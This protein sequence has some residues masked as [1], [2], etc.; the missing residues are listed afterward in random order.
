[1]ERGKRR[2]LVAVF[3]AAAVAACAAAA[4]APDA[5]AGDDPA[6]RGALLSLAAALLGGPGTL[7][8]AAPGQAAWGDAAGSY[9]A[10]RGV[11]CCSAAAALLPQPCGAPRAVVA[12]NLSGAGLTGALPQSLEPALAS[13]LQLLLLSHNPRLAGGWPAGLVLPQ[14][15][16]VDVR[17]TSL[18]GCLEDG[19]VDLATLLAARRAAAAVLVSAPCTLPPAMLPLATQGVLGHPPFESQLVCPR[20]ALAS[21]GAIDADAAFTHY[22]GC[23][24]ER[25]LDALELHTATDGRARLA[26]ADG[27][28]AARAA[29]R[30]SLLLVGVLPSAFLLL[31]ALVLRWRQLVNAAHRVWRVRRAAASADLAVKLSRFPGTPSIAL[32]RGEGVLSVSDVMVT[33]AVTDVEG[34]TQLWEWDAAVMDDAVERHNQVLRALLEEHGGHEVRTDGDSLT[35]AFH[36]AVDAVRWAV[37][38]QEALLAHP[39]PQRLL[40]HPHAAVVHLGDACLAGVGGPGGGAIS[41]TARCALTGQGPRIMAGLRVRIGINTGVPADVFVHDVTEAVE[42]RGDEYD[43]AADICDIAAGGQILLGP[44]TYQRW[45]RVFS[46]QQAPPDAAALRQSVSAARESMDASHHGPRHHS[47]AGWPRASAAGWPLPSLPDDE[48]VAHAA[49]PPPAGRRLTSSEVGGY[50]GDPPHGAAGQ[51]RKSFS[52]IWS[53]L[54]LAGGGGGGGGHGAHDAGTPLRFQAGR[55]S[56]G[57][58]SRLSSFWTGAGSGSMGRAS[59]TLSMVAQTAPG[60]A[61]LLPPAQPPPS[62]HAAEAARPAS[63]GAGRGGSGAISFMVHGPSGAAAIRPPPAARSLPSR[64]S[65]AAAAD[66]AL[67]AVGGGDGSDA[68]PQPQPQPQPPAVGGRFR[69]TMATRSLSFVPG[70]GAVEAFAAGSAPAGAAAPPAAAAPAAVERSSRSY[71][72]PSPRVRPAARAAGRPLGEGVEPAPPQGLADPW[73]QWAVHA[74]ATSSS[75]MACAK[76]EPVLFPRVPALSAEYEAWRGALDEVVSP[77]STGSADSPSG[78]SLDAMY[79]GL[80]AGRA[81]RTGRSSHLE[82]AE[83]MPPPPRQAADGHLHPMGPDHE[84]TWASEAAAVLRSAGAFV[85]KSLALGRASISGPGDD[86]AATLAGSDAASVRAPCSALIVDMGTYRWRDDD[87]GSS[88]DGDGGGVSGSGGSSGP[89]AKLPLHGQGQGYGRHVT[90]GGMQDDGAEGAAAPG[91]QPQLR[92]PPAPALHLVQVLPPRLSSR[93]MLLPWPLPACIGEDPLLAQ[94]G[95]G[96]LDAPGAFASCPSHMRSLWEA[97]GQP[98]PPR[99]DVTMVF[100]SA[101]GLKEMAA[102]NA[103][104]SRTCHALF[105]RAARELLLLSGGYES[106]EVGGSLMAAF[107]RPSDALE[108]ALALQLALLKVPWPAE[109][110]L[111]GATATVHGPPPAV[112][113]GAGAAAAATEAAGGAAESPNSPPGSGLPSPEETSTARRAA[114]L[115]FAGVRARV[116][117][118]RGPMDRVLPHRV[119]GRADYLGPPANRAA[120]LMAAA[121]GGQIMLEAGVAAAVAREWASRAAQAPSEPLAPPAAAA[122][123]SKAPAQ[124]EPQAPQHSSFEAWRRMADDSGNRAGSAGASAQLP[125]IADAAGT[126]VDGRQLHAPGRA[127]PHATPPATQ[128]GDPALRAA[129]HSG[130]GSGSGASSGTSSAWNFQRPAG[131]RRGSMDLHAPHLLRSQLQ[132]QHQQHQ[133]SAHGARDV[134]PLAHAGSATGSAAWQFLEGPGG[135]GRRASTGGPRSSVELGG[136]GGGMAVEVAPASYAPHAVASYQHSHSS[137]SREGPARRH[138]IALERA[139]AGAAAGS[140]SARDA[141]ARAAAAGST[142]GS[143]SQASSHRLRYAPSADEAEAGTAAAPDTAA[144]PTRRGGAG[145]AAPRRPRASLE[146]PQA[147]G[148]AGMPGVRH[149]RPSIDLGATAA[150]GSVT[151][152][153]ASIDASAAQATQTRQHQ[154]ALSGTV[155]AEIADAVRAEASGPGAARSAPLPQLPASFGSGAGAPA[156]QAAG[157]LARRPAPLIILAGSS[158]EDAEE[159]ASADGCAPAL[160]AAAGPAAAPSQPG[161]GCSRGATPRATRDSCEAQG[162]PPSPSQLS[163]LESLRARRH[164]RALALARGEGS[165]SASRASLQLAA[166]RGAATPPGERQPGGQQR[167]DGGAGGSPACASE[168]PLLQAVA[169]AP[170]GEWGAPA[171]GGEGDSRLRSGSGGASSGMRKGTESDGGS[172]DNRSGSGGRRSASGSGGR[173]PRR[174]RFQRSGAGGG[175]ASAPRRPSFDL[176][177]LLRWGH[178]HGFSA[179]GGPPPPD[180]PPAGSSSSRGASRSGAATAAGAGASAAGAPPPPSQRGRSGSGSGA[181]AAASDGAAAAAIIS[182]PAVAAQCFRITPVGG[183]VGGGAAAPL[184]G[185]GVTYIRYSSLPSVQEQ[186]GDESVGKLTAVA[187]GEAPRGHC[188]PRRVPVRVSL[189]HCGEF[190]LKGVQELVAVVQALPEALEGRLAL[191]APAAGL[192]GK[193]RCVNASCGALTDAPLTVWLPDPSTL[194]CTHPGGVAG[195]RAPAYLR[196]PWT[197]QHQHQSEQQ[198]QQP[199]QQ[200]PGAAGAASP[201]AAAASAG[202]PPAGP[203][204]PGEVTGASSL[205]LRQGPSGPQLVFFEGTSSGAAAAAAA[206]A[207]PSQPGEEVAPLSRA[208]SLAQPQP[209]LPARQPA[210]LPVAPPPNPQQQ[211]QQEE[212]QAAAAAAAQGGVSLALRSGL[213]G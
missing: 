66:A 6:T 144:E 83:P 173:G 205:L 171:E 142:D 145:A 206:A 157:R 22:S 152:R 49:A 104:M 204:S 125:T 196:T 27:L 95:P 53:A 136:R 85:R 194:A 213:Y 163:S 130:S 36:D 14:A 10:W 86:P 198:Q 212:Q 43:L 26:C 143:S 210:E 71:T 42:Y 84:H 180:Q 70:P 133:G 191:F 29:W 114:P 115:L 156:E 164:A 193:V 31:V 58:A 202:V 123:A 175:S 113:A 135:A 185:E 76:P 190:R 12:V 158:V 186:K 61:A 169:G 7:P 106:K 118:F 64:L 119:S 11:A 179:A 177:A 48:A 109:V 56:T 5:A 128:P 105:V 28:A 40:E 189:H 32:G 89:G 160:A 37:A 35:A 69:Q 38:V 200:Q 78:P 197:Q 72:E 94:T 46:H 82:T 101:V 134:R 183:S 207:G 87:A 44:K 199:K 112:A 188:Q 201:A 18:V 181:R 137:G 15:A 92:P 124:A 141:Q 154:G 99:P 90:W 25:A 120:R 150:R 33:W 127:A 79:A 110:G 159:S 88:G 166:A 176:A 165:P 147:A 4:A 54:G 161:T 93:L 100:A 116:G 122:A 3:L 24:C 151:R 139:F 59:P 45:N 63:G 16:L 184:S 1:M 98:A 167:R 91:A 80:V 195:R 140:A 30:R 75:G 9:C 153:R 23:G 62:V 57:D 162:V 168:P 51:A 41:D 74:E 172:G 97:R 96:Y 111:F 13:S 148:I 34:S 208:G 126:E 68:A 149:Y 178:A 117:I 187:S 103:G 8:P 67:A 47:A 203:G 209:Q 60:A 107:D 182:G 192:R 132:Q 102:V 81:G 131:L 129:G 170:P 146:A 19:N 52:A 21:G 211:Q 121:Q 108:W 174:G 17:N 39:W 73:D 77:R 20:P 50:Y 55:T 2:S 155:L 138:S 65:S